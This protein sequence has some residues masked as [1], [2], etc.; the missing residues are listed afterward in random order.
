MKRRQSHGLLVDPPT[1]NLM[2]TAGGVGGGGGGGSGPYRVYLS[3]TMPPTVY[4]S[5]GGELCH[6]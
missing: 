4:A 2:K 3:H 1:R 6:C 5:S